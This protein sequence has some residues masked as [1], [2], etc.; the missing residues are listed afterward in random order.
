M[1]EP[2]AK[3]YLM[4]LAGGACWGLSGC[5][6]QFLFEQKGATA[7]WL[8]AIRLLTAGLILAAAGFWKNGKENISLF[9]NKKDIRQLLLF[10]FAGIWVSQ[11]TYFAA[12]QHSNAGTATVLQ[13]MFPVLILIVICLKEKRLPIGIE[14]TAIILSVLGTVILGTHGDF[15]TLHMTPAALFFGLAAAV[16]GMLYNMLPGDLIQRYGMFQ[17]V[18]FGMIFSGAVFCAAVKPWN[19]YVIWD[20]G[21]VLTLAGVIVVG[22]AVGF[23][24]YLQGVS[25]IGPLKGSMLASI[26][27]VSAVIISVFW[28]GTTFTVFDLIG[29]VMIM[30]TVMLLT[31]KQTPKKGD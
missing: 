9:K 14:L 12:I 20:V 1:K 11:Y 17:V 15:T 26:E 5:C 23:G 25:I 13:Y 18:G 21:T 30:G 7:E 4:T 2:K 10:S 8:V 22:T 19:Q 31:W 16:G 3:G 6:G 24:L 27:P 29:F 28:L